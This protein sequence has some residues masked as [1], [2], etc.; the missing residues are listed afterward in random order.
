MKRKRKENAITSLKF[1]TAELI[2]SYMLLTHGAIRN[3][4]EIV[5]SC[6]DMYL[7]TFLRK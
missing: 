3:S 5:F 1:H 2:T 6:F 7:K 4:K